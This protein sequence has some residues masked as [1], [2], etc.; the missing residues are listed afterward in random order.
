MGFAKTRQNQKGGARS[1]A[2]RKP[3]IKTVAENK[4]KPKKAPG[5]PVSKSEAL[6]KSFSL[7]TCRRLVA[8]V[9]QH[10]RD[11][12]RLAS[13]RETLKSVRDDLEQAKDDNAQESKLALQKYRIE[14]EMDEKK[15][16][17]KAATLQTLGLIMEAVG[18]TLF[19][20]AE[21]KGSTADVV[22][23]DPSSPLYE[24]AGQRGKDRPMP[25]VSLAEPKQLPPGRAD[26]RVKDDRGEDV[27]A[28]IGL[29]EV[30]D[31]GLCSTW[32]AWLRSGVPAWAEKD[33]KKVGALIRRMESVE[34]PTPGH[35]L[36]RMREWFTGAKSRKAA[37]ETL[38]EITAW[39]DDGIRE[40]LVRCSEGKNRPDLGR[41]LQEISVANIE[42]FVDWVRGVENPLN[43]VRL[44]FESK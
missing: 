4:A 24:G 32:W 20:V 8:L 40:V 1:K 7:T 28:Y 5:E 44:E 27:L 35:L 6:D 30:V 3:K 41:M 23:G 18:G 17:L 9:E 29:P 36:R 34:C 26:E 16:S 38:P 42:A 25:Q 12:S 13:L 22:G 14:Q 31:A 2:P 33:D 39:F 43:K 19:E 15:Q 21:E 10:N 37:L 11:A